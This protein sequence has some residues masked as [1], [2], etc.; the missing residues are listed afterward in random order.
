MVKLTDLLQPLSEIFSSAHKQTENKAISPSPFIHRVVS[1]SAVSAAPTSAASR[2]NE[3]EKM[4][5][6]QYPDL[7]QNL[8]P[9]PKYNTDSGYHGMEDDDEMVLPD[10]QPD[11]QVSTQ[12][13]VADEPMGSNTL[14]DVSVSQQT[15]DDSFH[16]A[17][18][19]VRAP[20]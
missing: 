11:S 13:L 12:P 2:A 5:Q 18:E 10:T 19:N 17:Q 4:P 16:S 3:A 6:P 14:A 7:S 20:R 9:F 8:N 15:A 1:K